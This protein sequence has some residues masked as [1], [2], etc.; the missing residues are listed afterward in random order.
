MKTLPWITGAGLVFWGWQTGYWWLGALAAAL[1]EGGRLAGWEWD[2]SDTDYRRIWDLGG[3]VFAFLAVYFYTSEPLLTASFAFLRWL[4]MVFL[5]IVLAQWFGP[6]VKIDHRVFW[7][8]LRFRR[9]ADV[10]Q[11]GVNISA[12]YFAVCLYAT[13]AVD[14][15]QPAA[16]WFYFGFG[17]IVAV[18]LWTIRP[19]HHAVWTWGIAMA[20]AVLGGLQGHIQLHALQGR[21]EQAFGEWLS[22]W[23]QTDTG[24]LESRTALGQIGRLKLSG[25]IVFRVQAPPENPAPALLRQASYQTYRREIWASQ[26]REFTNLP[27]VADSLDSWQLLPGKR[28]AQR[29]TIAGYLR[30][31]EG[32]LALPP[33]SAM[34]RHLPAENLENNLLGAVRAKGGPGFMEIAAEYGP[35]ATLDCPPVP[36]DLGVP[37]AEAGAVGRM[38]GELGLDGLPVAEALARVRQFFQDK[39]QYSSYL[40][41]KNARPD[42]VTPLTDFLLRKRAGHCEYFATATVL[43]LRVAGVPA[44][45]A[46]GYS[47]QESKGRGRYVVRERHAHAWCLVYRKDRGAW[48]DFDTTPGGWAVMELADAPPTERIYDFFSWLWYEFSRWRYGAANLRVYVLGV[49]ALVTV[50]LAVQIVWQRR[51]ARKRQAVVDRPP[52]FISGNEAEFIRIERYLADK[53]WGRDLAETPR[54]WQARLLG[55]VAAAERAPAAVPPSRDARMDGLGESASRKSGLAGERVAGLPVGAES[56]RSLDDILA[57]HYRARFDPD[58]LPPEALETLRQRVTNWLDRAHRQARG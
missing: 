17:G 6:Q 47:V 2:L 29:V 1:L 16:A 38:V 51:R 20:L 40:G 31:G 46:V 39:F 58:G 54:R 5:P 43:M 36:E 28:T 49:L 4:P 8:W 56:L 21:V 23:G 22:K 55:L 33:G 32:L 35:G 34:L 57:L 3:A 41:E 53:G 48:E 7:W 27:P 37:E 13:T 44:R 25:K 10:P 26:Q 42:D 45:Y 30:R 52:G 15:K 19:R 9:T 12:V 14:L 11:G 50:L 24:S 18:A